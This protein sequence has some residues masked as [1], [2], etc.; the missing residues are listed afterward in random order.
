MQAA[1]KLAAKGIGSVEPNPAVGCVIVKA[2]QV[3]GQGSHK[4]FGGPHA[5]INALEDCRTRGLMPAGAT[6]YVTLEPCCHWG[7]TGPCT[8]AVIKAKVARVVAAAVDPS[9]HAGGKGLEKLRQAGIAV[10]VGLCESEARRLNAPF[11]KHVTTGRPWIILKWAQSI[12]GKLSYVDQSPERRWITNEASRRDVHRLRRRVGAILVG[13]N[14]VL[15]DD[16]LLT[17]RPSQG[18]KPIRVVLDHHLRIPLECTLLR[19]AKTNPVWIYTGKTAVEDDS[20]RAE[21]IRGKGAEVLAY[22][23]PDERPDLRFLLNRLSE[24][25]VQ[26]VLVEGGPHVAA[27]FLRRGLVDEICIYIAPKLLGSAGTACLDQP[28]ADLTR[29]IGLHEVEIKSFGDDVRIRGRLENRAIV[30]SIRAG[31]NPQ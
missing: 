20:Q 21:Q 3:I 12:D 19:T 15:A 17:P 7:K 27:S 18:R 1:L 9:A 6:L 22:E 26:Q 30:A 14:T 25:G 13:I 24:S 23:G 29:E 31:E 4:K 28:L 16:P 11:F 2:G 10:E 8:E 5:E